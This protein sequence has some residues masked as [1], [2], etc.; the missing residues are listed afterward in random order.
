M[1]DVGRMGENTFEAWCNSIG[2]TANKSQVDK[3]GWDYLVEFPIDHD[4]SLP[5]DLI[6][7]AIE[8][9]IQVNP[10]INIVVKLI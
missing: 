1:R 7:K 5:A 4:N 3:T 2:L 6:P 10:L 9:R 8:C